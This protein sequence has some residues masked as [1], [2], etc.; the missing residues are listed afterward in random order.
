MGAQVIYEQADE[1]CNELPII[2]D[3]L[4]R[5]GLFRTGHAMNAAVKAIGFELA[6]ARQ[7]EQDR[8]A[9]DG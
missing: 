5:A 9:S 4:F 7:A 2:Q 8:P 1:L 6:E 3:R